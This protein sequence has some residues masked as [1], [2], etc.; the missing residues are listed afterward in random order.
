MIVQFIMVV[1]V[2]L[3]VYLYDCR[4]IHVC[5]LGYACILRIILLISLIAEKRSTVPEILFELRKRLVAVNGLDE[6][7][8]FRVSAHLPMVRNYF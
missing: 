8:I 4:I 2:C 6:E 1:Y 3:Y 5:E 7:G